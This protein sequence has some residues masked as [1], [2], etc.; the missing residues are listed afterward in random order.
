[1][2]DSN[3]SK[4]AGAN[5]RFEMST[6]STLNGFLLQMLRSCV[7]E[8]TPCVYILKQFFFS[9]SFHLSKSKYFLLIAVIQTSTLFLLAQVETRP[10]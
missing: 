9:I 2:C 3:K 6:K 5:S 10:F 8:I 1:M 4:M 7:V